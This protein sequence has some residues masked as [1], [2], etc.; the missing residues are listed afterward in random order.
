VRALPP[1]PCDRRGAVRRC[2]NN[3][4][5][6]SNPKDITM[7]TPQPHQQRQQLAKIEPPTTDIAPIETTSNAIALIPSSLDGAFQLAGWLATSSFLPEKLRGKPGDVF[8]IILAGVELGLPPMAALRGIYIVNGKTAAEGRTKAAVC[9]QRGAA[10]Y[11]RRTEYTPLATTWETLRKGAVEPVKMRYTLEEAKAARL[12]SKDG[13]WQAFPQRMISHRA[14]G[15]L[16]DDVYPDILMGVATAEDFDEVDS[17]VFKAIGGVEVSQPAKDIKPAAAP[18]TGAPK[19]AKPAQAEVVTPTAQEPPADEAMTDEEANAIEKL[20]VA[21]KNRAQLK[22]L[23][24]ARIEGQFMTTPTRDRLAQACTD[25]YTLFAEA[26][27][28][29]REAAGEPQS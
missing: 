1:R 4:F 20:I 18:I 2:L 12:T 11:I 8:A 25:Q 16:L 27:K 23:I 9:L 28:A 29:E 13:P 7:A 19:T 6:N 14:L 10:V 17:P 3:H 24:K 26:A 22:E 15:W 5:R 21:T